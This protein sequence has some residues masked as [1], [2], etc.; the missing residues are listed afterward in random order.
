[1]ARIL[2]SRLKK[3]RDRAEREVNEG[4]SLLVSCRLRSRAK[5]CSTSALE[6]QT[7]RLATLFFRRPNL[8]LQGQFAP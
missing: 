3:L 4:F 8:W 5:S 6:N 7:M 1:M 2:S